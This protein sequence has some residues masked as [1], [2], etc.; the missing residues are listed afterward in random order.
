MTTLQVT[1]IKY[2]HCQ[3]L[4]LTEKSREI[5]SKKERGSGPYNIFSRVTS[6]GA[7]LCDRS[8]GKDKRDKH[9]ICINTF[10]LVSLLL[11]SFKIKKI[12]I[13]LYQFSR[14]LQNF[15]HCLQFM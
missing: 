14:Y 1:K 13:I 12:V 9:C 2:E 6:V 5:L 7:E 3:K 11:Q 8:N 4:S 10:F 15:L